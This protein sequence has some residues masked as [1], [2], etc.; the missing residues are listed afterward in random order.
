MN[1]SLS[2]STPYL[3]SYFADHLHMCCSKVRVYLARIAE[4]KTAYT[5]LGAYLRTV[6]RGE[7]S[8]L[9]AEDITRVCGKDG[10][11]IRVA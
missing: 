9:V 8:R 1:F 6:H 2:N 11:F 5:T 4:V 10:F 3:F 7:L